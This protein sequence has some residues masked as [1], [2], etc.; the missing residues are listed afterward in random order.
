ME[1]NMYY[2]WDK[3]KKLVLVVL[4]FAYTAAPQAELVSTKLDSRFGKNM[5]LASELYRLQVPHL[6]PP[7]Y[8]TGPVV[9]RVPHAGTATSSPD[10]RLTWTGPGSPPPSWLGATY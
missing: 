7:S 5:A 9:I 8:S 2:M 1:M 10:V 4:V 6:D 3:G